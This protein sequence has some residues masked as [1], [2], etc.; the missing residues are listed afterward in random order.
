VGT[1]LIN[2]DVGNQVMF[3][4]TGRKTILCIDDDD[5]LLRLP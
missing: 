4:Y 3:N 2:L 1:S 5:G